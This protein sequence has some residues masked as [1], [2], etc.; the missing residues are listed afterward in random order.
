MNFLP[1]SI[2]LENK[3]I[4]IVGG[5]NVAYQKVKNIYPFCKNITV[6]APQISDKLKTD[7]TVN[8]ITEPYNN[9]HLSGF[10]IVYAC[11]NNSLVNEQVFLQCEELNILC[12]P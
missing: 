10:Y 8:S 12:N 2:N 3:K 6:L 9:K 4:L 11:T 1:I 5:G 7:F